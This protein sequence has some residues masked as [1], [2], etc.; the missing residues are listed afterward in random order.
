MPSS[1]GPG[2]HA[3]VSRSRQSGQIRSR[4]STRSIPSTEDH[5]GHGSAVLPGT[6]VERAH[7]R[8]H[9]CDAAAADE[10]E[11]RVV[12][13]VQGSR[14]L[15]AELTDA[16]PREGHGRVVL[17]GGLLGQFGE[18]VLTELVADPYPDSAPTS[19]K[20]P[21]SLPIRQ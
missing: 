11:H 13:R 6:P 7:H 19:I 21:T 5:V 12:V 1:I 17:I 4:S 18:Q 3:Q 15:A 14:E 2:P 10:E 20:W 16:V 8:H 9:R